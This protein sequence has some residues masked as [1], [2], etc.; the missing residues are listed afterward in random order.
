MG[1]F[2]SGNWQ[3]PRK[4]HVEEYP[5]IDIRE[6]YR[7]FLMLPSLTFRL[8]LCTNRNADREINVYP[9]FKHVVIT[10]I[11]QPANANLYSAEEKIEI[12]FTICNYGGKRPWFVCPVVNCNKRAAILYFANEGFRCRHCAKLAY[13]SQYENGGAS[14]LRKLKKLMN[15]LG[16][17][18]DLTFSLPNKPARMHGYRYLTLLHEAIDAQARCWR[19]IEA[20][21]ERWRQTIQNLKNAALTASQTNH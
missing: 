3:R 15:K 5:R 7:Q 6:W 17:Q 9:W 19:E 16:A 12:D 20:G 2:G 4:G 11:N 10:H 14:A 1:G 18:S 8:T 21:K 13:A